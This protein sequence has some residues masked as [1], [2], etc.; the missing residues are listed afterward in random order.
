MG[1]PLA[2]KTALVTGASRG[3]GRAIAIRLGLDGALVAV[4]YA[5]NRGAAE[6]AV[7]EIER[8]GGTAFPIG[9]ELGSVAGIDKLFDELDR[10]LYQ[11][12]GS[13]RFDILINNAAISPDTPVDTTDE[14]L[15]D[16]VFSLNAK[17]PLFITQ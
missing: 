14:K 1:K 2:E 7:R 3:I 9:A 5:R 4:H 16:E 8:A 13:N 17:G 15:F 6:S 12:T 10:E 11:R